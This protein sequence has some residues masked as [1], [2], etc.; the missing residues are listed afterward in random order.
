MNNNTNIY[1]PTKEKN[2]LALVVNDLVINKD[3]PPDTASNSNYGTAQRQHRTHLLD[4]RTSILELA[5]CH[6]EL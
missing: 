1:L 4:S 2:N 5:I 6:F 3:S